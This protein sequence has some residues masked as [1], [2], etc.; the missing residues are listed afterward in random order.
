M[1]RHLIPHSLAAFLLLA[2]LV[3]WP[4]C[5]R[6][7]EG[8]HARSLLLNGTWE[9]ARSDGAGLER[10]E[11]DPDDLPWKQ[12]SLPG[13]FLPWNQ[14][15]ADHARFIW[16]RRTFE[17]TTNQALGLAVL[18][19]NRIAS[20][21]EAY[22]N[23][24]KVADHE[25]TGPFQGLIPPGVLRPGVNRIAL[26]V[27]GS[28]AVR[29]SRSGNPLIPCGFGP[30]MPEITDDVWLDFADRAYLKWALALPDLAGSRVRIRVT[31]V[32]P[33]PLDS[34]RVSARVE[35]WPDGKLMGE[36]ST[37]AR[38]IP[39]PEPLGG[40]HFWIDVPMLA[41]RP[42]TPEDRNL[43]NA[44]VRLRQGETTLD[45]LSFRFGMREIGVKNRRYQ[46]NG[47]SLWLRGSNLVFEWDWGD[48][49]TGHERDYLVTEA[50]E[51][52]LNSFRTHT[53]PLPRR[54]ADLCDEHGTMVLAEFPVL[55]NYQDYKFTAEEWESWHRNC[56]L[57]AAGW[58]ARLW[59][60]P[61]VV[62]WVLSNESR[63]DN[64]W[65]EGPF[66]RF[67]KELDPSRPTIRTG[68][69]GTTD[70]HDIHACGNVTE[71]EEGHLQPQVRRWLEQA[72]DRPTT[73]TE[74][75]ND[76]GH[77]RT[78]W[79]GIEDRLAND[80]AVAQIGGEHTEAMRRAR[81]DGIW[82]Y[83][84]AGWTRT[85]L[86]ARVRETG[87]GSAV[88]K[89]RFAAPASAVWHSTLSPVLASLDLFDP[90]YRTGQDVTT[91]LH[92]INESWN[93]T[94][95]HVDLLLTRENPEWIPEAECFQQPAA[96]WGFD[97]EL[98]ADTARKVPVTWRLPDTE[99][100]YCL[101]ARLTGASER[102]VLSQRF[103]RAIARSATGDAA[104]RRK[105]V[106]LAG[107]REVVR[108]FSAH[109]LRLADEAEAWSPSTH[110]VVVWR[111]DRL[112]SVEK[113]AASRL[114]DFA[115][116]GG[117]ILILA[118]SSWD[119][120]ELC[121]LR[122]ASGPR[123]SRVFPHQASHL[124]GSFGIEPPW[125]IRWNGYPGTV[126]L[127]PL[128]GPALD[129]G[130]PILWARDRKTT[131]MARVPAATGSGRLLVCQLDLQHRLDPTAT[132]YDPAA[133][134]VLLQLLARESW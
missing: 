83:M 116:R 69:T 92:L 95:V 117:P 64:A 60:H 66:Q 12:V 35:S 80:L 4:A 87:K 28:A 2:A 10:T 41:A 34:L 76:F 39:T 82:P 40:E 13:P 27:R 133:E 129:Q 123:F 61:S 9:F 15:V 68:T 118:A 54:W 56:L 24:T 55:F 51:M 93:D 101:T 53:R 21:A 58:M 57:D 128:S 17:L 18:R 6:E 47:R 43:Y 49:I 48:T 112:T 73:V 114:C 31:P 72:G 81:I 86:A 8:A 70:N 106:V 113:R 37:P 22:I 99:G 90:D 19:W 104:R 59:N 108:F 124:P 44:R 98:G 103:V 36:G 120:P 62:M 109:G 46:L 11:S 52:S 97:F 94:Q 107:D 125:L 67:V 79:S 102:P 105:L 119:W 121:D 25:P 42:W 32:G 45:E 88:W 7:S 85:R 50:R 23:G 126:S 130:E 110:M 30:G 84:Y 16:A 78:Q 38:V 20:G 65:E 100:T 111:P 3:R 91:D 5:A 127:A 74:Y 14:E 71:T 77:P 63:D 122:I 75:M 131:V 96:R 134:R 132:D 33:A 26:K 115:A 29:R 1:R 89:A